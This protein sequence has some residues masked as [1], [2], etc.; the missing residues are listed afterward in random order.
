MAGNA[1]QKIQTSGGAAPS[2]YDLKG[3]GI[4]AEVNSRGIRGER[5]IQAVIDQNTCRSLSRFGNRET[6]ELDKR[7]RIQ[8]LF[9]N[10]NPGGS[11]R[12]RAPDGIVG[13]V[14]ARRNRMPRGKIG[15]NGRKIKCAPV[16]Y[17]AKNWFM[18]GWQRSPSVPAAC[19]RPGKYP[20]HP[21]RSPRLAWK[22]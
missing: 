8:V 13:R 19:S 1:N 21:D 3:H 16:R 2:G 9:A 10:V 11:S 20:G 18:C 5:D 17:V 14:P 15:W 7:A 4:L 12:G 22:G 6:S